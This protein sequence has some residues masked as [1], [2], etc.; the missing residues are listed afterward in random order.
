MGWG[1]FAAGLFWMDQTTR[2][3]RRNISGISQAVKQPDRVGG[4]DAELV[5]W[6]SFGSRAIWAFHAVSAGSAV[7]GAVRD[8]AILFAGHLEAAVFAI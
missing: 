6:V 8:Q 7:G 2:G 1:N 4:G 5:L 3:A